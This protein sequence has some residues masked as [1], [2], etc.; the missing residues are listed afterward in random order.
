MCLTQVHGSEAGVYL[1]LKKRGDKHRVMLMESK[2]DENG[3]VKKIVIKDYGF[4]EKMS[5]EDFNELKEKY[6][7]KEKKTL[8]M[9]TRL[10]EALNTVRSVN[11]QKDM[12]LQLTGLPGLHYGHMLLIDLWQK[13]LR[14]N[15]KLDREQDK[16]TGISAYKI[17]DVAFYLAALKLID[18]S[19]HLAAFKNQ[20]AF[21][22][23]PIEGVAFDNLYATLDFLGNNKELIMRYVGKRIRE[24]VRGKARLLFYDCTNCYFET[25]YDDRE[26]FIHKCLNKVRCELIEAGFDDEAI[27]AHI[28]S[29]NFQDQLLRETE[30]AEEEGLFLRMR[31]LSKEHRYD[32][33]LISVALVIDDRGIPLD[34]QIY[35]GNCSEYTKMPESVEELKKKYDIQD[36]YVVADRGLNSAR[37]LKM[38]LEN[39]CGFIVAQKVSNQT[40]EVRNQM[41]DKEGWK[42]YVPSPSGD[43]SLFNMPV[44][45]EDAPFRYKVCSYRKRSRVKDEITGEI[46]VISVDCKIM[47]TFSEKRR[48]RDI[49]QLEQDLKKAQ[50]AVDEKRQMAGLHGAG[51]RA[52]VATQA[53]K[54]KDNKDIYKASGIKTG[55]EEE[56]R[57]IAGYAACVYSPSYADLE[58][59]R[60]IE[61]ID[62]LN[63]YRK[64]V[65]IEDC[66]R[67][68]KN[69]FSI[70][71]MY[72]RKGV[73]I[74]GHCLL[75]VLALIML[76]MIELRLA[77]NHEAL[78]VKRICDALFHAK[79][80]PFRLPGDA[81]KVLFLKMYSFNDIYTPENIGK[82][83]KQ[84]GLNEMIS[85]DEIADL[86]QERIAAEG[87]DLKK[88]TDA[89][90]YKPVPCIGTLEDVARSLGRLIKMEDALGRTLL[91]ITNLN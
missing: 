8:E 1:T 34:F 72:V 49:W 36:A 11:P 52:L 88:I 18:P 63:S 23:N 50:A 64:L 43:G 54:D 33:P 61:D 89:L 44:D 83:R 25:P 26:Q 87:N 81:G 77:R 55:I 22:C 21:F 37:N 66:F 48:Q 57:A 73:R 39:G 79:L 70:L 59:G 68:M 80:I 56:R 27:K 62:V 32:L 46:K 31:G 53:E 9:A 67:V 3:K 29:R 42:H 65:R 20:T 12:T 10:T 24:N 6:S 13:V 82:G 90:G 15:Y 2:H 60:C 17:S 28:D 7:A 30:D 74:I 19:S 16:Q 4:R 84:A 69:N 51:W 38:L 76:R 47:F 85:P 14:L 86:Y 5:D 75:C 78:S 91:K 41:L 71:P 35:E 45:D 40:G 58:A